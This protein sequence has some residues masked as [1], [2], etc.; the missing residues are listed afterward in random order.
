[1][2]LSSPFDRRDVVR[3]LRQ[4]QVAGVVADL[5]VL[6]P[7]REQRVAA[8]LDG[9]KAIRRA[10]LDRPCPQPSRSSHGEQG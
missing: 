10:S 2:K 3:A 9:L 1:M 7:T 5:V 4:E 8:M 6:L